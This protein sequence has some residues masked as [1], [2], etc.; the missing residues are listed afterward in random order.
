MDKYNVGRLNTSHLTTMAGDLLQKLI[1][2]YCAF[3]KNECSSDSDTS[4][5]KFSLKTVK[6]SQNV[7]TRF[8]LFNQNSMFSD[9]TI[10]ICGSTT[11][12]GY[13]P[14]QICIQK[15]PKHSERAW[16]FPILLRL[17]FRFLTFCPRLL[18]VVKAL[19]RCH[20]SVYKNI[21]LLHTKLPL[22]WELY[23]WVYFYRCNYKWAWGAGLS[24]SWLGLAGCPSSLSATI[25][26]NANFSAFRSI[27]GPPNFYMIN[28]LKTKNKKR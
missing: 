13:E 12:V 17:S 18:H 19:L 20:L 16:I 28:L 23:C 26:Q 6:I 15:K 8:G 1:C 14:M 22:S 5:D 27:G 11:K 9:I 24:D 3:F 7:K 21:A 25:E 4:F 2:Y 10:T